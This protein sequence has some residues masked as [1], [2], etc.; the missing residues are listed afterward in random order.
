MGGEGDHRGWDGWM[1]SSTRWTW[2]WVYLGSWWW[3]GKSGML[4]S[5]GS[6]R[7]RFDWV[8]EWNWTWLCS[9]DPEYWMGCHS[10]LAWRVSIERSAVILMGIPH[11]I[12]CYPLLL[13]H[14][15]FPSIQVFSNEPDLA[16]GGQSIG[17]SAS[18]SVLPVN[19]QDCFP[20]GWTGWISLQFKGLSKVFSN[21]KV[22]KHKFFGAQ[23]SSQSNSHIPGKTIPLIRWTLLAK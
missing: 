9:W 6:Q 19:I 4:Q 16:S 5:M 15:I 2:A 3:T 23:L 12:L 11:L 14:S 1:A 21:T 20:L 8:T 22:Q 13:P 18:V 17:V 7:V 10:L